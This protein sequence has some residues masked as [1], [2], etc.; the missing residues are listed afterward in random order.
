[1]AVSPFHADPHTSA[2]SSCRVPCPMCSCILLLIITQRPLLCPEW[3]AKGLLVDRLSIV[4]ETIK[5]CLISI[6]RR[7]FLQPQHIGG[8]VFQI[9]LLPVAPRSSLRPLAKT[10]HCSF[11]PGGREHLP[12]WDRHCLRAGKFSPC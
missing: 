2:S 12:D 6:L 7:T 8:P 11:T 1:M 5:G 9:C 3:H 10:G 4:P